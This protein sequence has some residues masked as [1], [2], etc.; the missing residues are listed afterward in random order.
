MSS[1]R[2]QW[3]GGIRWSYSAKAWCGLA[4]VKSDGRIIVRHELTWRGVSPEQAAQDIKAKMRDEKIPSL[5]YLAGNPE[6]FPKA[7]EPGPSTSETFLLA[8]IPM[9][10]GS[11]DRING[12]ATLRAWLQPRPL[13]WLFFHSECKYLLRTL[14]TLIAD[15][16]E[17][18]D[19]ASTTDSYPAEGLMQM[20]MGRPVPWQQPAV[21]KPIDP[22][23]AESLWKELWDSGGGEE[24]YVGWNRHS[25][26]IRA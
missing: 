10:R 2:N 11:K 8:G 22:L 4:A 15:D 13:P 21:T 19:I 20:V 9:R 12:W 16:T 5:V 1:A 7:N 14:P 6:M 23:S 3:V 25:G 17:P 26:R 24:R 18:D